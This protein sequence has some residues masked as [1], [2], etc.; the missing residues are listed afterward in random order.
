[1][2]GTYRKWYAVNVSILSD[3]TWAPATAAQ[4]MDYVKNVLRRHTG[5]RRQI[6]RRLY[7]ND[8]TMQAGDGQVL[9]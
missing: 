9:V 3:G 7:A 4:V 8:K 6:P 1:M 2:A 5:T